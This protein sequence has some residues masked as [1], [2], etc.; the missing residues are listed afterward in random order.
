MRLLREFRLRPLGSGEPAS[1]PKNLFL[2]PAT[3][4]VPVGSDSLSSIECGTPALD[5]SCP[6]RVYIRV[7]F[8]LKAFNQS[9]RNFCTFWL[10]QPK[11]FVKQL[12]RVLSHAR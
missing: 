10:G 9:R 8:S 1:P 12:F 11:R 4:I 6:R 3:N 5:F 7:N 2:Y